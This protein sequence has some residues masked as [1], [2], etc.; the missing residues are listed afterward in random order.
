MNDLMKNVRIVEVYS[1]VAGHKKGAS[2]G[3]D[4]LRDSSKEMNAE[5]YEKMQFDR[6]KNDYTHEGESR[7]EHAKY[8]DVIEPVIS[9]LANKV[10]EIRDENKFP[11]VI[12]GD[13]SSCAGTMHGLKMA[14]PDAEIGVVYI[15]AHAD[16][17]SPYT[18]GS[19]NMHGMPLAMACAIDNLECQR[20]ELSDA[21]K[22]YWERL[23]FM[24][25]SEPSIKPENVVFCAVRDYQEE[26]ME[27]IK[28]HKIPLYSVAEI[29]K[30][31]ISATVAEIFKKLEYCDHIYVSFDVDSVDPLYVPGTGTPAMN[32]L[33]YEQAMQLN[34]EL[35]KNEKVCCWEMAEINPLYNN[36]KDDSTRIFKILEEVTH[37]LLNNY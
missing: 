25:S 7:F 24:A 31:G 21:E 16:I 3:I 33:S 34:I 29:T 36:S 18:S 20:N 23:K 17:H 6:I 8:A 37:S 27:L 30:K 28:R 13:H 35:I 32:G 19:G 14:H 5:Y 10:K 26:E 15:D 12:A 11:I 4:A 22:E 9:K 1:D 2:L